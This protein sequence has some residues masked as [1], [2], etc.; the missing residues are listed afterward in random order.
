LEPKGPANYHYSESFGRKLY[1]SPNEPDL[2]I[3]EEPDPVKIDKAIKHEGYVLRNDQIDFREFQ[4]PFDEEN[5]MCEWGYTLF[6]IEFNK[7]L[8]P[9]K[10]YWLR[11]FFKPPSTTLFKLGWIKKNSIFQF[12]YKISL[13]YTIFSPLKVLQNFKNLLQTYGD[14]LR[15]SPI[16]AGTSGI[17]NAFR[18]DAIGLIEWLQESVAFN[19]TRY[20]DMRLVLNFMDSEPNYFVIEGGIIPQHPFPNL[21]EKELKKEARIKSLY[22]YFFLSGNRYKSNDA[23][24]TLTISSKSVSYFEYLIPIIIILLIIGFICFV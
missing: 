11:L 3:L 15:N 1:P 5:I 16:L 22:K 17:S 13:H 8:Q 2:I 14:I 24:F 20:N 9:N 6:R 23:K 7:P 18:Q 21:I 10:C 12:M 19:E 4:F